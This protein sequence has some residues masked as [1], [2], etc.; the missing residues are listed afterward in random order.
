ML[1]IASPQAA[2]A[3]FA[4]VAA[5]S[6]GIGAASLPTTLLGTGSLLGLAWALS[7]TIPLGARLRRSR[8]ELSWWVGHARPGQMGAQVVAGAGFEVRCAILNRSG[9]TV[10]LRDL[11]PVLPEGVRVLEG[12]GASV[13]VP[14]HTRAEIAFRLVARMASRVVIQGL[15]VTVPGPLSLFSAPLYFPSPLTLKVLPR[16]AAL[17]ARLDPRSAELSVERAGMTRQRR[18]GAGTEL[19][20]IR[21]HMPGDAFKS[22]AW[23]ASARAG[24]LLVRE[25]EREVQQ[26]V[27]LVLDVS[28]SMRGGEPGERKLD[29]GIELCARLARDALERGDRVGLLTT[30]GRVL[31]HVKDDDGL[32]HMLRIYDAL[33]DATEVVDADLTEI[34]DEGVVALLAHH[35]RRQD[36]LDVA[37]PAG[38]DLP[39]LLAH[40]ERALQT[41]PQ[42]SPPLAS[43]ADHALLRRFCR[44]RGLALPYRT[45]TRAFAKGPGLARAL[46]QAAGHTRSPRT[47]IVVSDFEG[48]LDL[49][50]VLR[51]VKMLR[52]RQ[53]HPVF[54]LPDAEQLAHPARSELERDLVRAF[55]LIE[56]QRLAS[57]RASLGRLGVQVRLLGRREDGSPSLRDRAPTMAA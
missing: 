6:V 49:D 31:A 28:G 44:A 37:T 30:D 7:S 12:G 22:I 14:P 54:V 1:P 35:V 8:V 3:F 17:P 9:D 56:R 5:I 45:E 24:T 57:V 25:V 41:E 33:L 46:S 16:A 32:P 43:S 29:H 42:R 36:G 55:G 52:T 48:V 21:E 20:E 47:V 15:A 26:T 23:K 11:L 40:A 27:Y 53:H 10:E 2:L 39:R 19:Y 34:D 18:R 51:T 4:C 38:V 50:P 13:V